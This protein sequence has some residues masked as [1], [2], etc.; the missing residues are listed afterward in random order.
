MKE[1]SKSNDKAKSTLLTNSKQISFTALSGLTYSILR[2]DV[3][4]L[5]NQLDS[6]TKLQ[7]VLCMTPG[8]LNITAALAVQYKNNTEQMEKKKICCLI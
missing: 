4:V 2:G 7:V 5:N 3:S 6:K 1:F 8:I